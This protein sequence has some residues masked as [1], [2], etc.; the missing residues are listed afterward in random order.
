MAFIDKTDLVGSIR[1]NVLDNITSFDDSKLDGAINF[2]VGLM[3]G[4][5]NARYDVVNIFNKTGTNRD[6]VIVDYCV[7]IALYRLHNL[8][9]PRK[10]A[11]SH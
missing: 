5:L 6:P 9:N 2:A 4:H 1:E 8:I 11:V 3:S 10:I 7:D